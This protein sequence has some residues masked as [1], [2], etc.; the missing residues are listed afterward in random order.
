M[1]K[2]DSAAGKLVLR[3]YWAVAIAR[4]KLTGQELYQDH[5]YMLPGNPYA[6]SVSVEPPSGEILARPIKRGRA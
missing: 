5:D 2:S 1:K 6:P 4:R 3:G